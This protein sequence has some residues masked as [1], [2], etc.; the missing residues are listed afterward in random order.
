MQNL[1]ATRH[2]QMGIK[3][4]ATPAVTI[5]AKAET[6]RQMGVSASDI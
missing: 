2:H 1:L 5:T 6:P 3:S 4:L